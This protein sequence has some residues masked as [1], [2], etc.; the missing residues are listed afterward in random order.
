MISWTGS[1]ALQTRQTEH[2]TLDYTRQYHNLLQV[3]GTKTPQ[4]Y[5]WDGNVA[6]ME[7]SGLSHF[8]YQD[9]LGSPMRLADAYG[10]SEE[11]YGYDEF[12][13]DIETGQDIFRKS[14]QSFG[15]TGYQMDQAGGLYFAQA[16]RYDPRVGRFVSEDIIKGHIAAPYTLNHYNYCHNRPE[17]LVDLNGMWPEWVEDAKDAV[18]NVVSNAKNGV[19]DFWSS[20]EFDCESYADESNLYGYTVNVLDISNASLTKILVDGCNKATHPNNIGIGTWNKTVAEDISHITKVGGKL[21]DTINC[22]GIAGDLAGATIEIYNDVVEDINNDADWEEY[23]SDVFID[24]F[25]TV[26]GMYFSAK[27]GAMAGA[28]V[29]SVVPGAGTLAGA[30]VGTVAGLGFYAITEVIKLDGKSPK[31]WSK[32]YCYLFLEKINDISSQIGD[33]IINGISKLVNNT[34]ISFTT[35]ME[36]NK[37][38]V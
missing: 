9:D 22:L 12:G 36:S 23:V 21:G 29:G 28:T 18:G 7:E 20:L 35:F 31:D 32:I 33:E 1:Q 38:E 27:A 16:R 5:Y 14:R 13:N 3:Y 4:T 11:I 37:C 26:V 6:A 25:T 2:Y 17:D 19:K 10:R 8:Y 34:Q 24:C 15:F 30:I